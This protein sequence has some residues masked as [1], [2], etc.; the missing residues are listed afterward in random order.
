MD[1]IFVLD[2]DILIEVDHVLAIVKTIYFSQIF[3]NWIFFIKKLP[4]WMEEQSQLKKRAIN[5]LKL[6]I[7]LWIRLTQ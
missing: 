2:Y 3:Q 7:L 4:I 6:S 1:I 5:T